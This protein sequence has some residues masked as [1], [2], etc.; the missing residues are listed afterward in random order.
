VPLGAP[1]F[2]FALTQ[3]SCEPVD[4]AEA[5]QLRDSIDVT[6]PAGLIALM[7]FSFTRIGAALG[8]RVEDV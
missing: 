3:A 2:F 7:V 8:M 4:A 6:T 1:P 5:R